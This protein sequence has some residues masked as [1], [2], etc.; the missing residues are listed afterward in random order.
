MRGLHMGESIATDSIPPAFFNW[1]DTK[2]RKEYPYVTIEV[3]NGEI[4]VVR[5]KAPI[6]SVA[7]VKNLRYGKIVADSSG[8][9]LEKTFR[10][11]YSREKDDIVL[12]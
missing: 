11:R 2:I 8:V 6:D 7:G 4:Q 3:I 10:P 1:L 9:F 5:V 12:D